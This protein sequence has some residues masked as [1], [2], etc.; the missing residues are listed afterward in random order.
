M[1]KYNLFLFARLIFIPNTPVFT[2]I[3]VDI[4]C[5]GAVLFMV[6]PICFDLNEGWVEKTDWA[7]DKTKMDT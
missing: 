3:F 2:S 7:D 4:F 1:A 6:F 5:A